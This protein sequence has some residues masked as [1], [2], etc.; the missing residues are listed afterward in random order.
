MAAHVMRVLYQQREL[1]TLLID[2]DPQFNLTQ[3]AVTRVTYDKLHLAGKTVF[4]AMEPTVSKSLFDVDASNAP[5][6]DVSTLVHRAR[7]FTQKPEIRLDLLTGDFRLVK[8]S[9]IRDAEKLDIVQQRFLRFV[10]ESKPKYGLICID[11]NPSSSFITSCALHACTHLLVPVRPDRY[12]VLG[13]ELLVDLL[14]EM[15]SI[16]PKPQIIV[17]LNGMTNSSHDRGIETELRSHKELGS[18]VLSSKLRWSGVLRASSNY[19]GFATD[20]RV[21]HTARMRGEIKALVSE[22]STTIG[23]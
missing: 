6:P 4:S 12:S 22:L 10:G 2:L 23:L 8:Y 16:H 18:R 13:L 3:T 1:A 15:P 11:C 5:P 17:L 14:A 19:T 20:K 7:Y 9:M 21:P